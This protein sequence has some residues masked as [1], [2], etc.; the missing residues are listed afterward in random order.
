MNCFNNLIGIRGLAGQTSSP[1]YFLDDIGINRSLL[2]DINYTHQDVNQLMIDKIEFGAKQISQKILSLSASK[3]KTF[4][5]LESNRIGFLAQNRDSVAAKTGYDVGASIELR[6]DRDFIKVYVSSI[7]LFTQTTGDVSVRVYDLNT[8][9]LLDTIA[10]SVIAGQE[11]YVDVDKE[12][13]AN[14]RTLELGFVY[15]ST[16]DSYKT[17]VLENQSCGGC[18]GFSKQVGRF[19]FVRGIK[20]LSSD[21]KLRT[22]VTSESDTAGM[23]IAYTVS[24]DFDEWICRSKPI[25]SHAVFYSVGYEIAKYGLASTRLNDS[26]LQL[27][28]TLQSIRDFNEAALNDSFSNAIKSMVI[29]KCDYCFK[30][31]PKSMTITTV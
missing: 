7:S 28:D 11:S 26:T 15:E 5:M 4:D 12:Y 17:T 10:A 14:R 31:N 24:C 6:S 19:A 23:S 27:R 13:K 2:E 8:G 22:N 30:C 16:F 3:I 29:P 20:I 18:G 21:N 9:Q 1:T 25:L